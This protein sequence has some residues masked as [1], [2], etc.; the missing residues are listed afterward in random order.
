VAASTPVAV[1][2]GVYVNAS[3]NNIHYHNINNNARTPI[4]ANTTTGIVQPKVVT[5]NY[6]SNAGND[7]Q[8]QQQQQQRPRQQQHRCN[9]FLFAILFVVHLV[10]MAGVVSH[11]VPTMV[12]EIIASNNNSNNNRNLISSIWTDGVG[13]QQELVVR[14]SSHRFLDGADDE[15]DTYYVRTTWLNS[16]TA[17]AVPRYYLSTF[18]N[19]NNR[20]IQ[21][22]E[23]NY[24]R[25]AQQQQQGEDGSYDS[26]TG[27][28]DM[29]DLMLLLGVSA[30]IS[31]VLSTGALT[32]M[33]SCAESLIKFA[34]LFNIVA[35]AVVS[36]IVLLCGTGVRFMYILLQVFCFLPHVT[37]Q[38]HIETIFAGG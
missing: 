21:N 34:L 33:I 17:V 30:I 29:A 25:R 24:H 27:T 10:F 7:Q 35:M 38:I 23:N 6:Y 8:Q 22:D 1:V 31:L 18:S 4:I 14:S 26:I 20:N 16:R 32:F 9:D 2:Q 19:R 3:D 36:Y 28:D 11:Y 15:N 5:D 13:E 37:L 12:S